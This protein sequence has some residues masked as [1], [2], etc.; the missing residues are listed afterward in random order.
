M[1]REQGIQIKLNQF[2]STIAELDKI[3]AFLAKNKYDLKKI[4]LLGDVK[5]YFSFSAR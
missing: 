4:V 1:L 3:F 5:H 2:T